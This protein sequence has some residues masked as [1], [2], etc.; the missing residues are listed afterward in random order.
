[1]TQFLEADSLRKHPFL[2]ALRRWGRFERKRPSVAAWQFILDA[3]L[4]LEVAW[5]FLINVT[6]LKAIG[7]NKF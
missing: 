7:S 1:M 5:W 3:L 6:E 4:L 2:H